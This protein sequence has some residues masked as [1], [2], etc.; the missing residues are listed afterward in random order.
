MCAEIKC[1]LRLLF[2]IAV[3]RHR[4]ASQIV[5]T[6]AIQGIAGD[7]PESMEE[8]ME[9]LFKA[10]MGMPKPLVKESAPLQVRFEVVIS[11]FDC[12]NPSGVVCWRV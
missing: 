7:E 12:F 9:P 3:L 8:S 6:S 11:I 4:I 2:L 10:I 1:N 5:Y